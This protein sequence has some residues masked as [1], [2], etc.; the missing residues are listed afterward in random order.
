M[1]PDGKS[2]IQESDRIIYQS[3]GSEANKLYK[4]NGM[5]YHFFSE[6]KTE[7]RVIMM[8]RSKS[9]IG[10]WEVKQLNHVD[11]KLDK[12]PNQGGLIELKNGQ[13]WF[14]THHGRGDWEEEPLVCCL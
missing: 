2:I 8:E 12:E 7:G 5:Y 14:F 1:T 11:K 13:W 3:Q 9:L 10:P 6:V 4:I